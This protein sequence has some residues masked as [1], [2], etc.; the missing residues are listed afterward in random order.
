MIDAVELDALA[1]LLQA[2]ETTGYYRVGSDSEVT[3]K[4]QLIAA[5]SCDLWPLIADRRLR[6]DLFALPSRWALHMPPLRERRGDIAANCPRDATLWAL[7]PRTRHTLD[8]HLPRS[9]C[10][11]PLA[12]YFG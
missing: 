1:L 5:A 8:W 6:P 7:Y 10:S 11:D 12:L 9:V 3:R 4:F 2:L